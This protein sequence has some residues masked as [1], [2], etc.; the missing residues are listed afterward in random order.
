MRQ[1]SEQQRGARTGDKW[2]AACGKDSKPDSIVCSCCCIQLLSYSACPSKRVRDETTFI[3]ARVSAPEMLQ[4]PSKGW[5]S[6]RG[7]GNCPL[8]TEFIYVISGP[9]MPML[10]APRKPQ[11]FILCWP[12]QPRPASA[13]RSVILFSTNRCLLFGLRPQLCSQASRAQHS[14]GRNADWCRRIGECWKMSTN[15][16]LKRQQRFRLQRHADWAEPLDLMWV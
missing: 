1:T 15:G 6:D 13:W 3:T 14:T 16:G 4:G 9:R 8:A 12:Q 11:A 10:R 2:H 5:G 7:R